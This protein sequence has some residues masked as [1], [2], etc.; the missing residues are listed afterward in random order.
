MSFSILV[1]VLYLSF[2]ETARWNRKTKNN[3]KNPDLEAASAFSYILHIA[4]WPS[5]W[6]EGPVRTRSFDPAA[7][8]VSTIISRT[9]VPS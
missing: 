8:E 5:C 2:F 4:D 9:T 1:R 6:P 7:S 3:T